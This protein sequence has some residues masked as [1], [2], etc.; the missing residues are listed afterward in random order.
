MMISVYDRHLQEVAQRIGSGANTVPDQRAAFKQKYSFSTQPFELQLLIWD[1]IWKYS[2]DAKIRL[3]AI[4]FLEQHMRQKEKLPLIWAVASTWQDQVTD[5]GLCDS[6]AKVYTRA[7]EEMPRQVYPRLQAWNKDADI[8]KKRQSV[9]S[10][11]YFHRTKAS[12]L[13]FKK[14]TPLLV[15]LLADEAYYVQKGLGWS[16]REMYSVYPD[17]AYKWIEKHVKHISAI[18]FT[19]AIEKMQP[20]EKDRLKAL[21]KG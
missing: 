19:I 15:S 8:W 14:I 13:P 10:L 4:F 1:S 20:E 5:W 6:L 12:Y 3:Q 7:L 11:L 16:I 2:N 21:R 9:V 17:D 18:A